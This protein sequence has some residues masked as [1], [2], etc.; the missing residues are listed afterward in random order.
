M[1]LQPAIR[2]QADLKQNIMSQQ[3]MLKCRTPSKTRQEGKQDADV[4]NLLN[5]FGAHVPARQPTY[6]QS[7]DYNLDL[8]Q[9]L[10]AIKDVK[11]AWREMPMELRKKYGS[12]QSLLNA[13]DQGRLEIQKDEPKTPQPEPEVPK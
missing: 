12:W 7:V 1:K 3:S 9:A 11:R 5:R 2:H 6:G 4:N 10:H 13:I 8:Q